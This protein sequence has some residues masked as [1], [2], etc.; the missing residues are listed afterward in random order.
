MLFFSPYFGRLNLYHQ[1]SLWAAEDIDAVFDQDPQRVCILQGPVAVKWSV[2]KDEPIKELLGNI[3]DSLIQRLLERKYGGDLSKV[4]TAAYLA[5][6]PN[7]TLAE[8]PGVACM[9]TE[10]VVTFQILSRLPETS[11][12]LEALAGPNLSWRHALISSNIIVQGTAYIDNPLRR[13]LAPR[14]GQ[15]I[16]VDMKAPRQSLTVYGAARSYGDHIPNFKALEI[17]VSTWLT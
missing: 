8:L 1:D 11:E 2:K 6:F 12:W 4:P 9:E 10:G 14:L 13:I 5:S 16:V 15:K 17:P 7:P 3:N